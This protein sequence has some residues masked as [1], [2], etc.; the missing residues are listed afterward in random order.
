MP[1]AI[2]SAA[3]LILVVIVLWLLN[4]YVPL[5]SNMRRIVNIVLVLI[6][7]GIVLWAINTYIPMAGSIKDILNIVVVIATCV[8]VLQAV[9]IWGE[10]VRVWHNMTHRLP[11]TTNSPQ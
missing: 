9:G 10:V 8:G 2:T 6:I 3:T 4:T 5:A 7:V 11:P 1:M